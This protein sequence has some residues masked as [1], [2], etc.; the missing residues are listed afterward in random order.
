MKK[1]LF[2]FLTIGII[3]AI[4]LVYFYILQ[5][6]FT[7]QH[8][9]FLVH[10]NEFENRLIETTNIILK[11][12][13]YTYTN[14]DEI[15]HSLE[16]LDKAYNIL[17]NAPI[18]EKENYKTLKNDILLLKDNLDKNK[19]DIELFL[20]TNANIK[21]SLLFL[22]RHIDNGNVLE[23]QD[24]QEFI[25]AIKILKSFNDV[26]KLQ[27][28]DFIK[29]KNYTLF[30]QNQDEDLQNYIKSFNL[31]STYFVRNYPLFLEYTQNILND[32]EIND[33]LHQ[34]YAKFFTISLSDFK[35]L[36]T[37]A[38]ILFT[39]FFLSLI[40]IAFLIVKYQRE[41]NKLQKMHDWLEHSLIYDQLTGV[42]NRTQL[43]KDLISTKKPSFILVDIVEFKYI[44][45]VYGT[46]I[47]NLLLKDFSTLLHAELFHIYKANLY[48]IGAD[49][50]GFLL[51]NSSLETTFEAAKKLEKLIATYVFRYEGIEIDVKVKIVVNDVAPI[52]ENADLILKKI[53]K[54]NFTNI[55]VY[56]ESMKLKQDI[57]ENMQ[58][59]IEIQNALEDDRIIPYFQPIVDLQQA[60]IVKYEALVRLKMKDG[61]ILPPFK[62]LDIAKKSSLYLEIT[63]TMILKVIEMAKKH[64][65]YRYS[66]NF[67]MLDIADEKIRE[68]LFDI[69]E[70]EKDIASRIDIELLESEHLEHLDD[71]AMF[72]DRLHTFGSNVLLDDFGTGYSN[73][74]YFSQLNI[75]IVKIDGSIVSEITTNER[76][77]HMLK[78]IKQ[79]AN[80]LG[81]QTVSEFVENQEIARTLR[82]IGAA[83]GQGYYFS[84]PLPEPL[85]D[86][87]V[88]I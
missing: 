69:L 2:V 27:D 34:I 30:C 25:K 26:K 52:L 47:G 23:K 5:K 29:D 7:K 22:S 1:T 32:K 66:L 36:N 70:K 8:R 41:H 80:G 74:S 82:D 75:D 37:F 67:S 76:K 6:D 13:L 10:I 16:H 78:S 73:F 28:F 85:E 21:N 79:F 59:V 71:V 14:Q 54:T 24:K 88:E 45:D 50:F 38:S 17:E 40:T 48:R 20:R 83:Y 62:F 63:K 77:F 49:E 64:P 51:E 86:D 44:N 81:M 35:E 56:E 31:H 84:A 46:E 33:E 42:Y 15:F 53:K 9:E 72:I 19:R 12:S 87:N 61:K 43:E 39:T 57:E 58:I 65:Q 18:L 68:M 11:N 4:S 55:A 60:K 3:S